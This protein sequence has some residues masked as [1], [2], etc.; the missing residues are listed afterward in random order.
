VVTF[1]A[2][3]T[4]NCPGGNIACVP[5]SG[6]FFPVGVTTVTCTATDASG[7]TD[8]C[9]FTVTV[10][11]NED[12]AAQCPDDMIVSTDQALCEAVVTFTATVTDNCPGAT[13]SCSP[14]SGSTFPVGTT[15]VTCTAIDAAGNTDDCTFTVTVEDNEDPVAQCPPDI[16]VNNDPG[17]C[18]AIVTFTATVT[19]NC[20]AATI[21]CSPPSGFIFPVGTTTVTCTATDAS[22]NTSVCAFTVTVNDNELPPIVCPPDTTIECDE[23]IDPQDL[24]SAS[25]TDNCG[26]P[27]VTYVD[28]E[29]GGQCA[30]EKTIMRTWT[31]TDAAGN[32]SFCMQT[33]AV[34]DTTPPVI[35]CPP[36]QTHHWTDGPQTVLVT[37]TDNCADPADLVFSIISVVPPMSQGLTID[38]NT[39]IISYDP[40]YPDIGTHE[41]TV[42][43]DDGCNPG[44]PAPG[45]HVVSN[46]SINSF[47]IHVVRDEEIEVCVTDTCVLPG[48]NAVVFVTLTNTEEIGGIDLL[49]SYDPSGIQFIV[50]E[51]VND[52][53]AWEYFTYRYSAEDNCGGGC[54]SGQIRFIGVADM[55]NGADHPPASA[56]T[57]NGEI[58]KLTFA[59][60]SDRSFIGQCF[61]I[62]WL[63]FECGDNAISSKSGDT[64]YVAQDILSLLPDLYCLA[65]DKGFTPVPILTFCRGSVCICPPPD[66]RGDINLN[67]IANEVADG[68]LFANYFIYGPLVLGYGVDDYYENRVLATDI[69]DDGVVLTVADLVYLIRIIT[70]DANPYPESGEG[71]KLTPL[72]DICSVVYVRYRDDALRIHADSPLDISAIA[73]TIKI[74]ELEIGTPIGTERTKGMKIRSAVKDGTLRIL[75]YSMEPGKLIAAGSG[76]VVEIP[77]SG[78]GTIE[79]AAVDASDLSG[80]VLPVEL[81]RTPPV[82]ETYRLLQNYPNPFNANTVIKLRLPEASAWGLAIYDVTGRLVREFVGWSEPGEV[83]VNW[84]G[85]N[86]NGESVSSG[87]FFYRM[88]AASFT[89]TKKMVLVK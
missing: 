24:G 44:T 58:I 16:T 43:V 37:A 56:F 68:V 83:S 59:T 70:G 21:S 64:M 77:I 2:S 35:I 1:S 63:W 78:D 87:I 47:L 54:P 11:D 86:K 62:D 28:S 79:L 85:K 75:V 29:T 32:S 84:D 22:G 39:G 55:P 10:E 66:D 18:D 48:Y 20:P 41:V 53:A 67:G 51:A 38:P 50:A 61:W 4:D 26:T 42:A 46:Q 27:V 3:F 65:G 71:G 76:P 9:S 15:T 88:T 82:P 52:L 6:S 69:N 45:E 36:D 89:Q 23:S 30:Q 49:L 13:I 34:V 57:L 5:P 12:P 81:G 60:S 19:D 17:Q 72:T 14:P 7:N 8:V 40:D 73:F 80:R 25:A 33:I 31:A 74:E